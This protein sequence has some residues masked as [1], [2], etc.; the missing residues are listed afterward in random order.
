MQTFRR[1]FDW[2][3]YRIALL[4]ALPVIPLRLLWRG[5]RERGYW[6]HWRE[7]MGSGQNLPNAA[8]WIH[9]VSV[10]ETRAAAPLIAALRARYPAQPVLITCMTATG[11]ATALE[12]YGAF[13][14]IHY[15]PYDYAWAMRRFIARARPRL[16]VLMETELWPNLIRAASRAGVPLVLA[17][18]RLSE[19]SAR[20]YARLSALTRES[21]A[22]F[23]VIAAQTDA[24]A[25]RLLRLG[26]RRVEVTGSLKFDAVAP[27]AQIEL[28]A[29]WRHAWG[30]ERRV[31]LAASTRA[32]EEA[33]ILE[34]FMAYAPRTALLV[35]VP[36]HPQRFDEVAAMLDASGL[37]WQR[38]SAFSG[39]LAHGVEVLL[40]DSLGEL[41]AYFAAADVAF[42]GGS[43]LPF[44]GQNL[45]EAC[46]VG[47][48]VLVGPHT[49]NFA[50]IARG[51]IA[52]GA[53]QR[54]VDA[55]ELI[56][57]AYDLLDDA[58]TRA[59]MR[60]AG[61]AFAATHRGAIDS[62]MALLAPL[63]D[64]DRPQP[65]RPR[66]ASLPQP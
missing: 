25:S 30:A 60:R 52:R 56:A 34:A 42:V 66:S 43:L 32:G 2:T 9:A 46:Q 41:F 35:I 50:E 14:H 45:I 54:V 61:L 62:L 18:A 53:A 24:D 58:A 3:L 23:S 37:S 38:R 29:R 10:G 17:N 15:L 64:S 36:R 5:V 19:R 12:L 51:A 59:A 40:G 16:C 13:A 48:P 57:A 65:D 55:D 27:I 44:G 31:L 21:L 20:G 33:L 49:Y 63:S 47:C 28:G 6:Q 22:A 1:L 7:R 26:A 4:A 11:R 39:E 8:L